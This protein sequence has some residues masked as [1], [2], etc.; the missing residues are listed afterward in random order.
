MV[1]HADRGR[2]LKV[3]LEAR[4][5]GVVEDER[6]L[7]SETIEVLEPVLKA[8]VRITPRSKRAFAAPD[9]PVFFQGFPDLIV[10]GG[11]SP[12][13]VGQSMKITIDIGVPVGGEIA[14]AA[15]TAP[16]TNEAEGAP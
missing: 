12:G 1:S 14:A 6:Q 3:E 10:N 15:T 8:I 9:A 2:N 16:W 7:A 5:I 4:C 11:A 13:W